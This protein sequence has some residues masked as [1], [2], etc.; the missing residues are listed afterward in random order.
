LTLIELVM[1]IIIIGVAVAGILTVM[2]VTVKASADPILR[3]QAIAMA[4]AVLEEVMAKDYAGV[5]PVQTG[6]CTSRSTYAYVD[7]YKCFDGS[8][9][10]KRILGSDMLSTSATSLLP[11]SYWAKVEVAVT[12][13]SGVTMKLVTVSVTDPSNSTYVLSGYK[14]NY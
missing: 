13:L 1:F 9:S 8:A 4:E 11:D 6:A 14:A 5:T 3:K 7:E 12:T 10:G 2:N